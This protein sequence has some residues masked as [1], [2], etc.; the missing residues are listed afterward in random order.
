M[1]ILVAAAVGYLL[2]SIPFGLMAGRFFK[3]VDVREYGSGKIGFTNTLRVL[4][5]QRS[6]VVFIADFAKGS[7]SALLPLIYSD[8]PW[9]RT[10][11]GVAAVVGH[12]WP[13]FA[14]FH[15]GRGVLTGA[16]GLFALNPLASLALVPVGLLIMY[17]TRYMSVTSLAVS[18]LAGLVFV[19][20]AALGQHP[21][22]Y[23]A[24][25]VAASAL[26]ILLHRENIA[27]LRSGREPKIGRGGQRRLPA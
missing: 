10:A 17:L 7:S 8:D 13:L 27:R 1:T 23:A 4:G 18:S 14:G 2:G 6:L 21:W 12:I 19:V 5:L 15:G 9:A 20:L 25:A 22:A 3:G 26:I 24:Y 16:G 11:G